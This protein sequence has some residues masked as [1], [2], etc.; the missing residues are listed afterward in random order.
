M[1]LMETRY[2]ELKRMLLSRQREMQS[3]TEGEPQDDL[4]LVLLQMKTE[5][6]NKINEAVVR[7]ERG[8]YGACVECGEPIAVLR[9][10]ALPFAVRCKNCEDA[11]EMAEQRVRVRRPWSALGFDIHD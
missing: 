4:D 10:R 2:D 6:L 9:L 1:D 3:E 7:L 5:T 8:R 11:V